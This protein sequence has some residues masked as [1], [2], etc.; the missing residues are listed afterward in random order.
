MKKVESDFFFL[1]F[2]VN[3]YKFVVDFVFDDFQRRI[4]FVLLWCGE[5]KVK[6]IVCCYVGGWRE[7]ENDGVY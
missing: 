3:M 2:F 5:K 4:E 6:S 7:R 1:L